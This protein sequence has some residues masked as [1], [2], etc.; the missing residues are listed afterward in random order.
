MSQ[1]GYMAGVNEESY[2]QY[3]GPRMGT[4]LEYKGTNPF[5]N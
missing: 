1:D 3:S 4:G 5:L 2:E